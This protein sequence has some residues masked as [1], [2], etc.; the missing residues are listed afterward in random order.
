MKQYVQTILLQN[1]SKKVFFTIHYLFSDH[2]PKSTEH[3][4]NN[5]WEREIVPE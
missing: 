1:H 4:W 3:I 2:R 5:V